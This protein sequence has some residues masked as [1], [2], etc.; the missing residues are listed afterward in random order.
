M[1]SLNKSK[2]YRWSR[3]IA[4]GLLVL[5]IIF[6]AACHAFVPSLLK[7]TVAE[8]GQKIGYEI[9]YQDLSLSPLR[10]R[11]TLEG[12]RLAEEGGDQLLDLKKLTIDLKW[13][14]LIL[15]E[16]GLDAVLLD[17]PKLL[18]EKKPNIKGKT[19][20]LWNWQKLFG[21]IEKSLSPK[22]DAKENAKQVAPL[23]IS[24]D[25]F[26][27][28]G[29]SLRLVDASTKLK[30]E[31]KPFSIKLLDVANYDQKGLVSG[32]RGQYDFNL[33]SL[34]L[35]IPGLNKT[36]AF[37][38][39]A[40]GG[41]LSNPSPNLLGAQLDLK[42]DEGKILSHWDLN[43]ASKLFEGKV[44]LENLKAGPW[45]ALLPAN[46]E[47]MAKS[48]E[49]NAELLIKLSSQSNSISGSAQL[50][51]VSVL[52][53]GEKTPLIDW[54]L[55]DIR[56]FEYKTVGAGPKPA[57]N[58]VIDE[59]VLEHPILR[60]EINAQGLSNFRRLFSKAAEEDSVGSQATQSAPESK[61]GAFGLDIRSVNLKSGEVFF[62]DM[63]MKPNFHVDVKKFN[64]S[65]IG[66]SNTPGRFASVAMEGV[67]ANSG[68]M[69]AKG[70]T[71][72][73]DPRR[74]HDIFMSF[75]NLPLTTFN[76]AVMT[77]AGYQI[78]GGKLNLNLS[79]RAKDGQLNG[80]NQIII[81]NVQLGDEVEG[82]QGKKLPLGLAIALL[83][84]SDD[85]IDVS[86]KIAGDVDSPEFS[87][88]GLVWQ[89]I[90]NVLTNVTTA[91]FR[92]LASI[93]G[94]GSDEG[95]NAVPGEAVF[96][97]DDQERL[98]K[99]GQFLVKR[100]NSNMEIIGTYDLVQDKLAMAR[101]KADTAILK[102]AGF[103]LQAGE[104]V[105]S[106]SLSDPRIQSGLKVA[107]AQYI[108][109]I[110][111]G[112]RLLMVPDGEARNEQLHNELIAG[113]DVADAE[114][115]TLAK[116]RAQLAFEIMVKENPGL[117]DRI[118]IGEVKTVEA[119]KNGIP[120]DMELRIK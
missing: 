31:L 114:L 51:K 57:T 119:G 84:D 102:D 49:I 71:S 22:D 79:Y 14:K 2:I 98:E 58:L 100:P 101:V 99:F 97:P 45:I 39:V 76:P 64:A 74:N 113:I 52:E 24:V 6:W 23:K 88:S 59:V 63:A 56:Q 108:G 10:L 73:D 72:F 91:P 3:R 94:M 20:N 85:I 80:S 86:V 95:V 93:L 87:A 96:L 62:A 9:T 65:F 107:Y 32:V 90:A 29:A 8:Y 44:K 1:L 67:V 50:N 40:I 81:K 77:Y 106:P 28:S 42:L 92:A 12:L 103:K 55:A 37:N 110:K 33:G 66:V 69:R 83:E 43:T 36:I 11:M 61:K 26:E 18:V 4:G 109:R 120:L 21:A 16:V 104:P 60:F 5:T 105:P 68:S 115:K 118:T 15:G 38:H 19:A 53:K 112:Q 30:E 7:K 54:D 17:E 116:T 41:S 13:T 111:L 27:V 89:A 47:L 75:K 70:Q 46:K 35:A 25:Q 34:Q 48:G 117:K 78:T 82:F